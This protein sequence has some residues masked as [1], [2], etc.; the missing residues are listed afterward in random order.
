MVFHEL[1]MAMTGIAKNTNQVGGQMWKTKPIVRK[2]PVVRI[3]DKAIKR[4]RRFFPAIPKM[5]PETGINK[6]TTHPG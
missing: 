6:N 5:I 1:R 4:C 3:G 2:T